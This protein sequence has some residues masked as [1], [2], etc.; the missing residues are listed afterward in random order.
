MLVFYDRY[1]QSNKFV[2]VMEADV[3]RQHLSA[4]LEEP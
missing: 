1:G 3:L 4:L 2:G